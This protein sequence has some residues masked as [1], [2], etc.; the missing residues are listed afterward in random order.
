MVSHRQL[1]EHRPARSGRRVLLG[2]ACTAVAC[3]PG[4][5]APLVRAPEMPGDQ[6]RCRLA[7]NQD[8]PLVTEWP[9]SEKANLEA[10]LGEGAVVVSYSGCSLR[11]LPR[12]RS[13][14]AY[15]WKRTTIATDDI[16]IRNADELFAKLPLGAAS[17]EGELERSGRLDVQTSVAGQFELEG[18]DP[19]AT[20]KGP[21]C[22]G[23]T[24]VL[25]A[26]SVGA[27]KLRSGGS[28]KVDASASFLGGTASAGGG[29]ESEQTIVREAGVP[30]HCEQATESAPDADCASPIQMFLQPLPASVTDRGPLGTVKVKFL[31]VHAEQEWDVVVGDRTICKTPCEKWLD[32]AMPYTL[33]YDPGIFQ[34]NEYLEVPDLR[35]QPGGDRLLV[36]A[37][38]RDTSEFLGGIMLTTFGGLGVLAGTALTAAGC[39]TQDSAMC[40]GGLITLPV[41]LA[42]LAPGVWMIVD[43]T[44]VVHVTPMQARA[45]LSGPGSAVWNLGRMPEGSG[46]YTTDGRMPEGS[47]RLA[48]DGRD[49]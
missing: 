42:L 13:G 1:V 7:A 17:L 4:I 24:H 44:G 34:R 48:A 10:R 40:T 6:A 2:V 47:G 46:R 16:E 19:G 35:T 31:P 3:S 22:Q 25:G 37:E 14:G 18:F 29:S 41:G 21:E 28:A 26:L 39:G 45:P 27:F 9:A 8:N 36:R 23:A 43:S 15:R 30:K 33:K 32:P 5:V 20:P 11:M 12:C 49:L 38:P